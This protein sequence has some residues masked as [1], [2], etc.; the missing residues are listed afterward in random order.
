M[1]ESPVLR[2]VLVIGLTSFCIGAYQT[3]AGPGIRHL[4]GLG[5]AVFGG[6]LVASLVLRY[7]RPGLADPKWS[8]TW[9]R[10]TARFLLA[11]T[12]RVVLALLCVN[13]TVYLLTKL[14]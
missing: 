11:N 14:L 6:L 7:E 5:F 4:T 13:S 3:V 12:W 9:L 2:G 10:R 8:A 1:D